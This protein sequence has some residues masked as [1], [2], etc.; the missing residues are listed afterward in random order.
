MSLFQCESCGCCENTSLTSQAYKGLDE[1][2][3]WTYAPE[4]RGKQL[5]SACSPSHYI[6][7]TRSSKGGGWH[8]KFDRVFLPKGEFFTNKKGNLE[9]KATGREDF[10]N[11]KIGENYETK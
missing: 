10:Y 5:C 8:G 1:Y 7:G 9:H 3:D 2:Y 6:D 11:F 4:L